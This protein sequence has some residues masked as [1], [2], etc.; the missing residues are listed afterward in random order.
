MNRDERLSSLYF[1]KIYT[2]FRAV[3][4]GTDMRKMLQHSIRPMAGG[5]MV[6]A[7]SGYPT[8][9]YFFA[10]QKR[11]GIT[12]LEPAIKA[13]TLACIA[14]AALDDREEDQLGLDQE[15]R[16]ALRLQRFRDSNSRRFWH[17]LRE[18]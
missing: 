14:R 16:F 17:I 8:A 7:P 12:G 4:V 18:P 10:W 1:D 15:E 2:L 6:I 3:S 9:D 11:M 13:F 5:L